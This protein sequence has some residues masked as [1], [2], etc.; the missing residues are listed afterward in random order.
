MSNIASLLL[1]GILSVSFQLTAAT[2]IAKSMAP[3][4]SRPNIILILTDDQETGSFAFMPHLQELL[5]NQGTTLEN[6]IFNVSLCC[7]SRASILRGQYAHNHQVFTIKAPDGGFKRFRD[8][9]HEQSTVATWLQAAGY[10]T[11]LLGKYFN[12]YPARDKT[13]VPPGWDEWYAIISGHYQ[14]YQLNENGEIVQYGGSPADYETDVLARKAVEFIGRSAGRSPFFIYLAPYAPHRPLIPAERHSDKFA[15][16]RAPR[17]PSFNEADV[18]DKPAWIRELAAFDPNKIEEI[19]ERYRGRLRL[20][21]AVDDMIKSIVDKL[22]ATGQ[23][24]NTYLFF[25]T[26][27]GY[28]LGEQR[29]ELGKNSPYEP[30]IRVPLVVRGP[31]VPRAQKVEHLVSNID[32]APTFAEIAG[33]AAPSF[34]DGVS[35]MPLLKNEPAAISDWREAVLIQH[36]Q[37]DGTGGDIPEFRGIRT[38][39]HLYVE[40]GTDELELY[41]L[42]AD[43]YQLQ[44]LHASAPD[45]L[46]LSMATRLQ[47][48]G[49]CAGA[50]CFQP[51]AGPATRR[52]LQITTAGSG[53]VSLSPPPISGTYSDGTEV[54][55]TAIADPGW[56]LDRWSG[57][58]TGRTTSA[59]VTMDRDRNVTATFVRES[60]DFTAAKSLEFAAAQLARTVLAVKDPG[61]YPRTALTEGNWRTTDAGTWTSGFF[62]GCLWYMYDM[63]SDAVWRRR[64]ESWTAGLEKVKFETGTHDVGFIM[65]SSFG[66][67]Y[68]LAE[69]ETY[70]D[71][72]LQTAHSLASRYNP[73]VGCIQSWNAGSRGIFPVIVDNLMNLEILFWAARNGG[74]QSWYDMAVSHALR[75]R[76]DHVREDGGTYQIVD[77]DPAT[78]GITTKSSS[79]GYQAEST[80][81]RGQAWGLYGFTMTYRETG[82]SRFLQTA[83]KLADFYID[84][85]P[86]DF[87]PFWDFDA[88]NIPDEPK[89]ASAAAI[90]ASALVELSTLVTDTGA[91]DRY[92]HTARNILASLSSPAY[93]AEGSNSSA[94]LL[95][96][97]SNVNKNKE[98]DVS[99]IHADYYF[100]E[101]LLRFQRLSEGNGGPR[102][103]RLTV[104][105]SGAGRVDLNP[106]PFN[107]A[108]DA[109]TEVQLTAVADP[110]W[111]FSFWSEDLA[112]VSNPTTLL[113]NSEKNVAVTFTESSGGPAQHTLTTNTIGD[114]RVVLNPAPVDGRYDEGTVVTLLAESSPGWQFDSWGGDDLLGSAN[115]GTDSIRMDTDK[116]VTA[117]FAQ[118]AGT[119]TTTRIEAEAMTLTNFVVEVNNRTWSGETGI[120]LSGSSGTATTSLAPGTYDIVVRYLDEPDGPATMEARIGGDLVDTWRLQEN[121]DAL[122]S[123]QVATDYV[124]GTPALF[125]LRGSK[126]AGERARVDYVEFTS[127]GTG[128]SPFPYTMSTQIIGSGSVTLTPPGGVYDPGTLV[129]LTAKPAPGWEFRSWHGDILGSGSASTDSVTMTSNKNVTVNFVQPGAGGTVATFFPSED[130]RVKSEPAARNYG[131][132]EELRLRQT[133]VLQYAYLKFELAQLVG[134]LQSAT[135]R[136]FCTEGSRDGGEIYS[137]SNNYIGSNTAWVEEGMDWTNKP[138]LAGA[139][140]S[141]AGSVAANTWVEFDVSSAVTGDGTLSLGLKNRSS[142]KVIYSSKEGEFPPELLVV[143]GDGAGAVEVVAPPFSSLAAELHNANAP[144]AFSLAAN[145]PNPFNPATSI[146]YSVPAS[147]AA[148]VRVVMEIFN[149]KGEKVITLVDHFHAPGSYVAAWN[150]RDAFGRPGSSGVYI[151]RLR[152]AN[153]TATRSMML[154]K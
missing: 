122:I 32:L 128:S 112:G 84:N 43:P 73:V 18:S 3:A 105:T 60:G 101:A 114:G 58:V 113:M 78:G 135:L 108:Y 59:V 127:S 46:I 4:G 152:A 143:A 30:S 110:G 54:T 119:Q 150:G 82:D 41:D 12:Q 35:L 33:T 45:D 56:Q 118:A 25:M 28:H 26:D 116:L 138:D 74:E 70:R 37:F 123:R 52:R 13:Y 71:I 55:L 76:Q 62:P 89:E 121:N 42:R 5:V 144:R 81:A 40:Y 102:R 145:Y 29:M 111:Q 87:V 106:P 91:A 50:D 130:T 68:R 147:A 31:G 65:F 24:D 146:R 20:L 2:A 100:I 6:F 36:W 92:R 23:L 124:V 140:L 51:G 96:S 131:S 67:G 72:L 109:G 132:N 21:L 141:R 125:E 14:N 115:A 7:P 133:S 95:H 63:T 16:E 69:S 142:D 151:Y 77:Y 79:Q 11:A 49:D 47:D 1:L 85:L 39:D 148:G 34:V 66:N 153:F 83:R 136:L 149:I 107:G 80:W 15:T 98:V 86:E 137:V 94:I 38:N 99:L 22:V 88:P 53:R 17:P 129:T 8:L 104:A 61:K 120:K 97:N 154:V 75:T 57:D 19:D 10:R 64:A 9:G 48:L 126:N 103:H 93:L 44:S 27:N 134:P 90:A 117:S 139:I